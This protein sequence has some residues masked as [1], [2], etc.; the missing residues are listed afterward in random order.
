MTSNLKYHK[1]YT[2]FGETY[3]L[4]LPLSLEGLVPDDDSVRLLSHE[5][6]DLDYSKLYQAYSAKGRNPA[7]DPKTMF[8]ILTYAYS[9]GIYS[10][11]KIEKACTRDINFMWL[12][13]GQKA[14][15]HSTIARFRTGFLADACE[16]LFYQMVRRLSQAGELSQETVFIDGTK[17]EAC[18]NKYT[19]VWKKSVGKWEEKML[20]KVQETVQLLNQE[21]LQSFK[22]QPETRTQDLQEICRFLEETCRQQN[23]VFVYGRGKRKSTNQRYLELFRRFLERQTVY[24]WHTA[25]F[26]GRN[27]YSKTDPDATFMHMKDDHMRNAQ[28]KP[29]YNVQIGVDSEYVVAV[30]I[31]QDRNDVWTLVPFLKTMEEKL[32][33]RYPSV[34]ADSGYESEEAYNFL[35]EN[36]QKPYIKPQTYEKWKKRSFKKDISKRENMRYNEDT[37][38]YI[39]HAEKH[40]PPLFVKKQKSKSGYESEV[41]VYECE[42]CSGCPY[43]EKCTKA[44][45]NKR[46]Y[47]SKS[48]LEKRQESYENILSETGILYRM[49]RSIQ[50]EGAFGVLKSDYQFQRFLLRGKTKVRLEILLLCMGYNL[51]KLHAKIQNERTGK[52]LFP[53]KET[54]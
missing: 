53:I 44:K 37:D 25:S 10:T 21:Y 38:I 36:K 30:D 52:Y 12:L 48:F 29:G 17:L 11:R 2:E 4:V 26:Q 28:L 54:A 43:K 35:R 23:T 46:L 1:N 27:N 6:E 8:K 16:A 33:F 9:Q 7:V 5:L 20:H 47:I 13:A 39:C 19:F 51:N 40:L 22:T 14:P 50:V 49:N 31:F 32:G 15:D 18:A 24:D 34:T 41:T 42:N 45:G 3:Q